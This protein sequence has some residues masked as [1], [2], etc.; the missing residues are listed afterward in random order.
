MLDLDSVRFLFE[1]RIAAPPAKVFA[2]HE[3]PDAL[4]L[5]VPPWEKVQVVQP[6]SSLQV[7]TRVILRGPLGLEWVAEHTRY[8]PPSLFQDEMVRG[9]FKKWLHTHSMLADG[10][11]TLLRDE[12]ELELP[13][14]MLP[15]LPLVKRRLRKMFA[16]RHQVTAREVLRSTP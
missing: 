11:G 5:L 7:G 6:P 13:L 2:F 14:W 3:R 12:V 9:P 8:Q 15:G 1:S 10:D 16:Y 4:P